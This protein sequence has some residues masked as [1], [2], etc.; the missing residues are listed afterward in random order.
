MIMHVLGYSY[1]I[2][3]AGELESQSKF[4]FDIEL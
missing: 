3:F 1:I 2:I 4:P